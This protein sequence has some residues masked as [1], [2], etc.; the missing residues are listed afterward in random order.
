VPAEKNAIPTVTARELIACLKLLPPDISVLIVGPHGV[1]K[2]NIVQQLAMYFEMPF[3]DKRLST[4]TEGDMLGLP[5]I[6]GDVTEWLPTDWFKVGCDAPH[7]MALEEINRATPELTNACFQM[8]LDREINGLKL[9]P[10]SRIYACINSGPH[11]NVNTLDP[12][13]VNRFAIFNLAPDAEDWLSWGRSAG[14]DPILLEFIATNR[15]LLNIPD[16]GKLTELTAHTT[17]RS[18]AAVDKVLKAA[19]MQPSDVAGGEMPSHFYQLCVSLVGVEAAVAFTQFL[20]RYNRM[21]SPEELL[22]SYDKALPRIKAL[23]HDARVALI[24]KIADHCKV[25]NW[26]KEQ[27]ANLARFAEEFLTSGEDIILIH[28]AVMKSTNMHNMSLLHSGTSFK[29]TLLRTQ[30]EANALKSGQSK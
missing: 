13:F 30:R 7:V 22:N 2:S 23:S 8:V 20:K 26:T 24:D 3:I 5:R 16:V 1:G 19:G 21:V 29:D 15:S 12:A 11:Y 9:H 6:T 10:K 17:P 25:N 27:V 4:M 28:R 14:L 18:W